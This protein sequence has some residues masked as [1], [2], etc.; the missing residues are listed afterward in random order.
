MLFLTS[1]GH[2]LFNGYLEGSMMNWFIYKKWL[3]SL[4]TGTISNQMIVIS[5]SEREQ[6]EDIF[7]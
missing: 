7:Y 2:F 6:I 1:V 3:I 4:V 5:G